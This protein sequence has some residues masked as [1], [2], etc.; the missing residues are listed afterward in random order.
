MPLVGIGNLGLRKF[1]WHSAVD[2]LS[3]RMPIEQCQTAYPKL[4]PYNRKLKQSKKNAADQPKTST[5][6]PLK[7]THE[8]LTLNDWLEVVNY[9][10]THQ[11]MTQQDLVKIFCYS[12]RGGIVIYSV[13][14]FMSLKCTGPC[15]RPSPTCSHSCRTVNKEVVYCHSAWHWQSPISM[16]QTYG[17]KGGVYYRANACCKMG[18]VWERYGCP[19]GQKIVEWQMDP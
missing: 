19:R 4:N 11:L 1:S 16:V 5:K 18:E 13:R 8:F 14:T 17:G 10:D 6:P 15:H 3:L 7:T 2:S 9:F 12:A